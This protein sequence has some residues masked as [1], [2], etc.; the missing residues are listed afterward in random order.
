[1]DD[2]DHEA[3]QHGL[4]DGVE[5]MALSEDRG[6]GENGG[7]REIGLGIGDGEEETSGEWGRSSLRPSGLE[8]R[9]RRDLIGQEEDVDG[10]DEQR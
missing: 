10:R 4:G 3:Q 6:A 5:A 9:R 1:M 7:D 8:R 2:H